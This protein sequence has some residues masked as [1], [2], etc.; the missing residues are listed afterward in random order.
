MGE[1]R[2][3]TVGDLVVNFDRMRKPLSGREREKRKGPYPYYGATCIFDYI[4]DYIFDGDYILL[5]EDGTVINE[6]GSPVLQRISGKTWV[7]N[8][9]HVLQNSEIVDFDYLYYALKNSKF[10]GA[11]TGAVQLKISQANM[12]AVKVR[13]HTDKEEQKAIARKLLV[14]DEKIELNNKIMSN[15]FETAQAMFKKTFLDCDE[16]ALPDGWKMG[17]VDD[18]IELHDAKRVPLSGPERA[19]MDKIY[20]YY[21]ATSLMDYVEDYLFDGIYLLLGEDGTVMDDYGFPI[22]Q[23]VDGKFWVNNHAHILTGKNGYS[24]EELYLFFSLTNVRAIV[25]GAVQKK[26]SQQNLKTIAAIIPTVEDLRK[27]DDIIQP[28]FERIRNIRKENDEL[29]SLMKS[30]LPK[31][32]A[33]TI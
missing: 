33:G 11:V 25:T 2:E 4:D 19:K 32:M 23:Y 10:N 17:T 7:N 6:D 18:I 16:N 27:F 31:I 8:H 15:L 9:A 20:P 28:F 13:I 3:Y 24:V 12:N 14:I 1:M 21:G 22:L 30:L 26:I 5:G 29:E